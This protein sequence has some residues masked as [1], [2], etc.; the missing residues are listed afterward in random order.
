M[1]ILDHYL[2]ARELIRVAAQHVLR[3]Y[4]DLGTFDEIGGDILIGYR[5]RDLGDV[6]TG[7]L[8]E[9]LISNQYILFNGKA[10]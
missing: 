7:V 4:P 2:S 9:I 5:L 1:L 3:I 8:N 10:Q 6:F